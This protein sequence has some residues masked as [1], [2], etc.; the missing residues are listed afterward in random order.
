[1]VGVLQRIYVALSLTGAFPS[2]SPNDP[3][4]T[5]GAWFNLPGGGNPIRRHNHSR[6]WHSARRPRRT[7]AV[8]VLVK[9]GVV[10]FR[11][12]TGRRLHQQVELDS[13]CLPRNGNEAEEG[14][15]DDIAQEYVK[16]V[17]KTENRKGGGSSATKELQAQAT[18]GLQDR[19]GSQKCACRTES[20]QGRAHTCDRTD[21]STRAIEKENTANLPTSA[22][23]KDA[24][25]SIFSPRHEE[26]GA[27]ER[28][29]EVVLGLLGVAGSKRKAQ[30]GIGQKDAD[31][32]HPVWLVGR[33]SS[34][35][36]WSSSRSLGSIR[37]RPIRKR[38][39]K[40]P[41]VM[42]PSASW[43]LSPSARCSTWPC[44]R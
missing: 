18:G 20:C 36:P 37:F 22:A 14:L 5:T 26:A 28:E 15:I 24:G 35:R 25:G 42:C 17:E 13:R 11:G 38:Q 3:F 31:E 16:D 39:I 40:P 44:R 43:R 29:T 9:I 21:G 33:H 1:M 23:D 10:L 34:A 41:S 7:N 4:S 27:P 2:T 6:H 30:G 19:T 8:L 32:F 12:C